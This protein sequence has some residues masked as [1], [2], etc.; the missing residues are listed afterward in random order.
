MARLNKEELDRLSPEERLRRLREIEKE[1]TDELEETG[2]L[3]KK[4][5]EEIKE[6]PPDIE[7]PPIGD[8]DIGRLFEGEGD[9]GEYVKKEAPANEEEAAA[10]YESSSKYESAQPKYESPE[11]PAH[12]IEESGYKAATDDASK[13][14]ATRRTTDDIT[15]YHKG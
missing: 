2:E 15:K 14:T 11:E 7:A 8:V 4:V 1:D 5:E 6:A 3:I 12:K 9:L 10:K 13:S